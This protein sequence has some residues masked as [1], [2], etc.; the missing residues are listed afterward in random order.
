MPTVKVKLS[1]PIEL[2]GRTVGT[3]ELRE[4]LGGSYLSL[5]EPRTLVFNASGSGY[6][7]ENVEVIR[8]YID[9]LIEHESGGE[10]VFGLLSL[11]DAMAVKDAMLGFFAGA[12]ERLAARKSTAS[13]SASA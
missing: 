4:P 13:S 1:K 2:F 10:S 6:W 11:E 8:A 3:V 12:A 7:V 9:R 5:G